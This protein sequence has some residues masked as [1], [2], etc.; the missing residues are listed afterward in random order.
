MSTKAKSVELS[1]VQKTNLVRFNSGSMSRNQ[2]LI[3]AA[4]EQAG[5]KGLTKRE[6]YTTACPIEQRVA[7]DEYRS[8][9]S[10]SFNNDCRQLIA[11]GLLPERENSNGE[12][13]YFIANSKEY[14]PANVLKKAGYVDLGNARIESTNAF[15]FGAASYENDSVERSKISQ[16]SVKALIASLKS[17]SKNKNK[18]KKST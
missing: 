10:G 5:E 12:K 14:S 9:H 16:E 8:D 17:K 4:L 18:N 1:R 13:R 15:A 11:Q 6:Y 7:P 3:L 2:A